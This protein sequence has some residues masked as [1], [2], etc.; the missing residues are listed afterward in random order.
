MSGMVA[1]LA[2]E[3]GQCCRQFGDGDQPGRRQAVPHLDAMTAEQQRADATQLGAARPH[4]IGVAVRQGWI[5]ETGFGHVGDGGSG[6]AARGA[7]R[8]NG[9]QSRT[10]GVPHAWGATKA[11]VGRLTDVGK[12]HGPHRIPGSDARAGGVAVRPH[13][14]PDLG[15]FPDGV[16]LMEVE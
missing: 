11:A 4:G 9:V 16:D 13:L 6:R 10:W 3:H 1:Q 2:T 14:P 8:D 7:E 5:T 12:D 15:R